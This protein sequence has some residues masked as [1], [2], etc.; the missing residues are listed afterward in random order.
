MELNQNGIKSAIKKSYGDYTESENTDCLIQFNMHKERDT[1][2]N[3]GIFPYLRNITKYAQC[4]DP[5]YRKVGGNPS[6]IIIFYHIIFS[7]SH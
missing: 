2:K 3:T 4:P 6:T 5:S 7:I 1:R